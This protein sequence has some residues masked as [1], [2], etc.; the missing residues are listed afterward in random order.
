MSRLTTCVEGLDNGHRFLYSTPMQKNTLRTDPSKLAARLDEE[1]GF[2]A[3]CRR[4]GEHVT[5]E[6]EDSAVVVEVGTKYER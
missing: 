4:N 3:W 6:V 2:D 5:V 1:D